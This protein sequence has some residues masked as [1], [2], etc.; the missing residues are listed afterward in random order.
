MSLT[1]AISALT[2]AAAVALMIAPV[3][4]T[5]IQRRRGL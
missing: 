2:T 1:R 5:T 4:T 3:A